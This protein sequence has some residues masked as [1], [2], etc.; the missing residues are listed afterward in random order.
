MGTIITGTTPSK[1][2]IKFWSDGN[3]TWVTPTDI[4]ENRDIKD[5]Q[6]KITE[7][8]LNN[9][10]KIPKN[11]ILVTCIASIGKNAVLKVDG[12]CNQ[13]I[14][15]IVPNDNYN[16]NYVYYLI[17]FMSNYMK[18]VAGTSATSII[19]KDEF[20]KIQV[21]VHSLERQ[22]YIDSILSKFENKILLENKKL[23]NLQELKKGLMQNM[24]V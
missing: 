18:S 23:N 9:G 8:G 24:F 19:N 22:N 4:N 2:N 13:Q 7:L 20:S 12:S 6:V 15:A 1:A 11:S 14:N 3:I 5:S 16:Y 21:K 17:E 10:R